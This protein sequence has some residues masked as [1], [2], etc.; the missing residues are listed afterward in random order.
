MSGRMWLPHRAAHL[1]RSFRNPRSRLPPLYQQYDKPSQQ[2]P[3][4]SHSIPHCLIFII[5]RCFTDLFAVREA[6][7]YLNNI[8]SIFRSPRRES[9]FLL[10]SHPR[11]LY[12][13]SFTAREQRTNFFCKST[14]EYYIAYLSEPEKRERISSAKP[15]SSILNVLSQKEP[16]VKHCRLYPKGNAI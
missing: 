1:L 11:V 6:P 14:L 10:R 13:L 3:R 15:P 9:E 12:R 16:Y 7:F 8:P 4:N 5:E 2:R